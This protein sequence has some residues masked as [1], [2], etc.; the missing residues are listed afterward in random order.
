MVRAG[1]RLDAGRAGQNA[2]RWS[3]DHYWQSYLS[4]T[5][6]HIALIQAHETPARAQSSVG[7]VGRLALRPPQS[8]T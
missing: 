2:A 5:D 3:S 4:R 6:S 7:L 1:D 8:E